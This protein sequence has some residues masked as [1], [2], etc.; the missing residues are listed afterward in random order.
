MG[1]LTGWF[2]RLLFETTE[3]SLTGPPNETHYYLDVDQIGHSDYYPAAWEATRAILEIS[4]RDSA[5]I[6]ILGEPDNLRE[7]VDAEAVDTLLDTGMAI[8]G[9]RKNAQ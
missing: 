2:D 5:E 3:S 7:Y 6:E 4:H 1:R 9:E 8:E